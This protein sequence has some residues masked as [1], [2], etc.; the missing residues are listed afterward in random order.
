[1]VIWCDAL[2]VPNNDKNEHEYSPGVSHV[3]MIDRHAAFK[4]I[5]WFITAGSD[6]LFKM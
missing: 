6:L 5:L 3:T 2:K 4:Y 1:M